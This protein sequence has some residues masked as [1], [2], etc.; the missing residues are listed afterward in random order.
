MTESVERTGR[1]VVAE[2]QWHDAGWGAT[3]ISRLTMAGTSMSAPPR[4]VSLPDDVLIPYAPP[5]EDL[6]L[7]S[8][9]RMRRARA[10]LKLVG[11]ADRARHRPGQLSG[12]Q[13]QRVG[14]ARAIVTDPTLLLCDEPTGDL[15]RKSGDE[16]LDLLQALN[17][18]GKTIVMVTHDP[19][20]AERADRTLH[21]E[22]GRLVEPAT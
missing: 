8:A 14:I 5:L 13:E 12:G 11:L 18:Q 7:P 9:E 20:A 21:L 19:H 6:V 22:K 10:A 16:I 4:A 2:E 15:D 17:R 3:L 1:L